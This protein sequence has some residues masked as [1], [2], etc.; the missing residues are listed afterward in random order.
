MTI[1][2][3]NSRGLEFTPSGH[4]VFFVVS[5]FRT[6]GIIALRETGVTLFDL[7]MAGF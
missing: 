2:L 3:V 7:L 6:S 5:L 1:H 4:D